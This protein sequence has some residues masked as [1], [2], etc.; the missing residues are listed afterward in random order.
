MKIASMF[1]SHTNFQSNPYQFF[2]QP[3][4]F[5]Q[6]KKKNQTYFTFPFRR[7]KTPSLAK[8]CTANQL[9][10]KSSWDLWLNPIPIIIGCVLWSVFMDHMCF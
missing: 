2:N 9:P 1:K 3:N 10:F 6:K 8:F 5:K 4:P 7:I